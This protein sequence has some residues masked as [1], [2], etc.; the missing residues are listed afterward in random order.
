[1]ND[2]KYN[3]KLFTDESIDHNDLFFIDGST[4]P[5]HIVEDFM[6]IVDGHFD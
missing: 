5:D 6:K 3:K 4:P 2:E 1:L